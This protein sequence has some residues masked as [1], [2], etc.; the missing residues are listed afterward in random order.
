MGNLD[1]FK[2]TLKKAINKT[3]GDVLNIKGLLPKDLRSSYD[4]EKKKMDSSKYFYFYTY[5]SCKI[6]KFF[7]RFYFL[8]IFIYKKRNKKFYAFFFI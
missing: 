1:N 6:S 5:L 2:S 8:F 7:E 3:G 4:M